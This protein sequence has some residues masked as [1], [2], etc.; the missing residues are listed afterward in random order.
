MGAALMADL[1]F[2]IAKG[3]ASEKVRVDP[4]KAGILLLRVAESDALLR[5]RATVAAILANNTEATFTNY[6]RKTGITAT[7]TVDNTNNWEQISV[8]N[9]T[10]SSAGGATNN[11]LVKLVVFYDAGGTDATRVPLTAHD[12][13]VTDLTA[14]L[15]ATGFYRAA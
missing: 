2:N 9:Q 7:L 5:T 12:F 3:G 15:A 6:A 13:S 4:T 14:Q 1:V 10:W 11:T 8:P